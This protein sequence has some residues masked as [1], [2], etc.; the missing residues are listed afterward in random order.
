MRRV[1]RDEGEGLHRLSHELPDMRPATPGQRARRARRVRSA[2]RAACVP[3]I[4][5]SMP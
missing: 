4:L 2:P 3:R 5:A 1:V